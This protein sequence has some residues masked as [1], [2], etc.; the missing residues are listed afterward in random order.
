M[1]QAIEQGRVVNQEVLNELA[2]PVKDNIKV[3]ADK[4]KNSLDKGLPLRMYDDR[5]QQAYKEVYGE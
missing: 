4:V 3:L 1:T 2:Q 5:Y